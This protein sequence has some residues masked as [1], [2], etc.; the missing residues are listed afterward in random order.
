M[1]LSV[2]VTE[3]NLDDIFGSSVDLSLFLGGVSISSRDNGVSLELSD[4]RLLLLLLLFGY[5]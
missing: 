1:A 3:T 4:A 2:I 5:Y